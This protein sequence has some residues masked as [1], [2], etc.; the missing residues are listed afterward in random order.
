[1]ETKYLEKS[2]ANATQKGSELGE[3]QRSPLW[4]VTAAQIK[5]ERLWV[6]C[7]QNAI[8][9]QGVNPPPEEYLLSIVHSGRCLLNTICTVSGVSGDLDPT[10][11][12]TKVYIVLMRM[13]LVAVINSSFSYEQMLLSDMVDRR[14]NHLGTELTLESTWESPIPSAY[15]Y[16]TSVILFHMGT[17]TTSDSIRLV[18]DKKN[19]FLCIELAWKP[20]LGQYQ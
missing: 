5:T 17:A 7:C 10:W 11:D 6:C 8:I 12:E 1:M 4:E 18:I 13:W 14:G 2:L 15:F 20:Y 3:N 16:R 9:S 19:A